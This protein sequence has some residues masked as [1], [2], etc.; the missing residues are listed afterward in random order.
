MGEFSR[1]PLTPDVIVCQSCRHEAQM[2]THGKTREARNVQ[3]FGTEVIEWITWV[4]CEST[5]VRPAN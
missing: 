4:N 2:Y 3:L 5:T 1:L